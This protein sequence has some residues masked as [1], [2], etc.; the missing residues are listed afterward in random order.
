S[1]KHARVVKNCGELTAA[2]EQNHS[3]LATIR[4]KADL[5]ATEKFEESADD[6]RHSLDS[7]VLD[8]QVELELLREKQKRGAA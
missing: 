1:A 5:L 6:C 7:R 4:Q 3:R 2:I 8:Q